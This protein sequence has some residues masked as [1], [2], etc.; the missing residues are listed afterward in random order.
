MA[1]RTHKEF[2]WFEGLA[3]CLAAVA[4][5]LSSEVMNQWGLYFY[6]PSE[7]VGR[8]VYVTIS[9]VWLIFFIGTL[10]DAVTDPVIGGWSDRV[11]TR[12]GLFRFLCPSGRRR[13]FIF[14][15]SI[16]MTFTAVAFWYPP[17]DGTAAAR[18]WL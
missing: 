8:T 15:G 18:S 17:V 4:T 6:S 5:Q 12:A 2:A 1:Q 7:G 11:R 14:W 9:L 3:L 13:P 10:W 16:L